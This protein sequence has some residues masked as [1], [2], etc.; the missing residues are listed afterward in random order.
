MQ[1]TASPTYLRFNFVIVEIILW[2]SFLYFK[3]K[4]LPL[5]LEWAPVGVFAKSESDPS[6]ETSAE[7][8]KTESMDVS[9]EEM[10]K[11]G[12]SNTDKKG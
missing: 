7:D 6:D 4:H 3:F 5:Y 12:A 1:G 8:V 2:D 11:E 10:K 9:G